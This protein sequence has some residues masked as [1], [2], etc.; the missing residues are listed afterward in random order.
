MSAL[1]ERLQSQRAI[2]QGNGHHSVRA[3]VTVLPHLK[4]EG[5]TTRLAK[6]RKDWDAWQAAG[7]ELCTRYQS[8]RAENDEVGLD[9]QLRMENEGAAFYGAFLSS[10]GSGPRRIE[11]SNIPEAPIGP[12][13]E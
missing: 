5:A 13:V 9:V 4:T 6:L 10:Q 7:R 11:L 12:E 8:C 2:Y 3:D 1:E